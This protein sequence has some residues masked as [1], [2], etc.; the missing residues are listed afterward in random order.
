MKKYNMFDVVELKNGNKATIMNNESYNLKIEEVDNNGIS[1][2]IKYITENDI[3]KTL[4][5]K[6][7]TNSSL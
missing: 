6:N 4:Y 5:A 2:G 7:K 3:I 1:Q